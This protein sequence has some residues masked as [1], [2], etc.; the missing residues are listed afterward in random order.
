MT[1]SR[2]VQRLRD[3]LSQAVQCLPDTSTSRTTPAPS[4]PGPSSGVTRERQRTASIHSERNTLFKFGA[5]RLTAHKRLP[6]RNLPKS[7]K[8]KLAIWTHDFVCLAK[9]D[10]DK[11]P[12]SY[13][14]SMLIA[15]GKILKLLFH[16]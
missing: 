12:T 11:S 16:F 10:Q 1:D 3:L 8:K 6:S 9:K 2:Q 14:R 4:L 5:S 15:A 13:E 7:K